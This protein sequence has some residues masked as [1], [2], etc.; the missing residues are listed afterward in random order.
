M[1]QS[2]PRRPKLRVSYANHAT[3]AATSNA[4]VMSTTASSDRLRVDTSTDRCEASTSATFISRPF[5]V[6]FQLSTTTGTGALTTVPP[7]ASVATAVIE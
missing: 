2:S 6:R 5:S 7:S 1:R 4:K 3:V